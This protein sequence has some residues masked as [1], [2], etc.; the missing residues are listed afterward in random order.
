MDSLLNRHRLPSV[1]GTFLLS[2]HHLAGIRDDTVRA[3]MILRIMRY[4]SFHP[5]GSIRAEGNRRG[6][7]VHQIVQK[8]WETDP[9]NR[10]I[11]VAGG[12][13]MWAPVIVGLRGNLKRPNP[14]QT[15][16]VGPGERLAWMASRQP[17]LHKD[18]MLKMG[19]VDPLHVDLT[20]T[21]TKKMTDS[22][23]TYDMA[24][25]YDCRF[26]LRFNLRLIPETIIASLTNPLVEG[27]IMVKPHTRWYW[28]MVI[29]QKAGKEET[30]AS[31]I[32]RKNSSKPGA[33]E[34]RD[35]GKS[36]LEKQDRNGGR[37]YGIQIE[38]IRSLKAI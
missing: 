32:L 31:E 11:F 23:N 14:I 20:S 4:I 12:G 18:K 38:W 36:R 7:S 5:W 37:P 27:K 17:P 19:I 33:H 21:L 2:T 24:V 22:S 30:L 8:I 9:S 29:W 35:L 28:P 13:V 3:A 25:L 34:W 1:P 15:S 16:E 6:S 10:G 26:L